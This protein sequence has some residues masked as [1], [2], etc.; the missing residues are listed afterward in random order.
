MAVSQNTWYHNII[1][2]ANSVVLT[3]TNVENLSHLVLRKAMNREV[4]LRTCGPCT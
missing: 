1:Y 2:S 4:S 3:Y